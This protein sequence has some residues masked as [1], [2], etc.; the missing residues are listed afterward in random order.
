MQISRYIRIPLYSLIVFIVLGIVSEKYFQTSKVNN[1]EISKFSKS[2]Q[3]RQD[4]LEETIDNIVFELDTI[5][6]SA[7]VNLFHHFSKY[8]DQLSKDETAVII[9]DYSNP[10][11]WSSNVVAFY[12]ELENVSSGLYHLPNGWYVV[13]TYKNEDYVVYGLIL[14]KYDY[15]IE[16]DYLENKFASGFNLPSNYDVLFYKTTDSYPIFNKRR[17]FLFSIRPSERLSGMYSGIFYTTLFYILGFLFGFVFLFRVLIHYFHRKAILRLSLLAVFLALLY[18]IIFTLNIPKA[19]FRLELFSPKAFAY[20]SLWFSMGEYLIFSIFMFFFGVTFYRSFELPNFIRHNKRL[21]R[22]TNIIMLLLVAGLLVFIRFTMKT[23]IM[24]SSVSYAIYRLE[25]LNEYSLIGYLAV[26]F[27]FLTFYF[28]S[29]RVAQVCRSI[30]KVKEYLTNLLIATVVFIVLQLIFSFNSILTITLF[31]VVVVVI[32]YILSLKEILSYRLSRI[33][34]YVLVF[35]IFTILHL[36]RYV[37]AN[38]RNVQEVMVMNLS[39]EHDPTAELFL[40]DIDQ[41]I[42]SD[43]QI[44]NAYYQGYDE[45]EEYLANEYFNNGYFRDYDLQIT[46][47]NEFDSLLVQP[48]NEL[49]GCFP[50]FEEMIDEKSIPINDIS[51]KFIDNMNGRITYLG[52]FLFVLPNL[53]FFKVYIELNSK[54]LSEGTGFPE[55]LL[56]QHSIEN[57][58]RNNFSFAKYNGGELIDRSGDFLYGLNLSAIDVPSDTIGFMTWGGYEHCYYNLGNDNVILVSRKNIRLFDYF[59]A[60]PYIFVFLFIVS[61]ILNIFSTSKFKIFNIW[62]SLRIRIQVSIIGVVMIALLI[63]GSGTIYYI[64]SQYRSNHKDDLIEKVNSISIEIEMILGDFDS[65]SPGMVDYLGYELVNLSD[66]F[67]TDINIYDLYGELVTT[68]RYEIFEKGLISAQMNTRALTY[69]SEYHPT[70][71]I[72]EESIGEMRYLS[73]YIPL[74]NSLGDQIGYINLPYFTHERR[75]RQEIT[76]FVF[77][78]INIYVFLLMASILVAYYISTRI[79]DPLKMIRENLREVKLGKRTQKLEYQSEDEI[80]LLV[81]EYNQMLEELATSAELLARSEREIAWREMAKQIAHEIKNPLT[82]MKLNIQFLQRT[83]LTNDENSDEKLKRITDTLI[84]QIDNLSAIATEFS[85]F[86]KIPKARNERFNLTNRLKETLELYANTGQVKLSFDIE[87]Y[88]FYIYADQEQFSRAIINLIKNAIQSIPETRKGE[89]EIAVKKKENSAV[90]SVSD[91]GKGIPDDLASNIFVPNFTT[92]SS[93]AGLGLAIT[94]SIVENFNG[95]IWF[96]SRK[97]E[98][99]TFFI[100]IPIVD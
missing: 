10:Y 95:H 13:T 41:K 94:K 1:R 32:N 97:G 47:C 34:I 81:S 65:F 90:I 52:N 54:L 93:G 69:L 82:P 20:S 29:L 6:N 14:V 78:F 58:I 83:K 60:F 99:T 31:F 15:E 84:E 25:E 16:N 33:V 36:M 39:N 18:Y 96:D 12:N 21:L 55:L 40:R 79:T 44:V 88:N 2:L 22:L 23:L 19:F 85:N 4:H 89:I 45:I 51:F 48:E 42:K 7:D 76:T 71:Y 8:T 27:Q 92:K 74:I 50:F 37:E 9:S 70:R 68:S 72:H 86:A 63:V 56:P 75:F 49:I 59:I 91:N 66:I 26:A 98:G 5:V 46:I 64:V 53:D 28:I 3:K 17:Q 67:K 73:A 43:T 35:T 11:F 100:K 87:E 24:N 62:Q 57:R 80:G 38:E 61:S 30:F 77:A